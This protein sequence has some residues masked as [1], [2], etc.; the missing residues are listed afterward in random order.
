MRRLIFIAAVLFPITASAHISLTYPPPRG[1]DQKAQVCGGVH[2]VRGTNVTTLAP[3]TTITVKWKE[4]IDHPGHYRISFDDNGQDFV[5][6]ADIT[7]NT[8][9]MPNVIDD[10]IP[11]IQGALPAGGREYTSQVTL[12]NIECD[13]CT[14]Q[15]TQLMTDKPPYSAGAASDDIYY[16]CADI[17]LSN[18]PGG[19]DAGIDPGTMPEAGT[20]NPNTNTSGGC[21]TTT[22]GSLFPLALALGAL[23]LRRRRRS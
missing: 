15:V 9:G 18:A 1:V 4:T 6:P 13:N 23:V 10:M 22:S 2:S 21:A 3:G 5:I 17:K 14:L 7:T 20:M 12:P 19:V 16:Q 8:E 11:D